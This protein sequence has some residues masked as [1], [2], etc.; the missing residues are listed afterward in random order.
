MQASDRDGR[1]GDPRRRAGPP[2]SEVLARN[3]RSLDRALMAQD[4]TA[5]AAFFT[6]DAV[7]GESGMADVVGREAI[8]EFLHKANQVRAVTHH[9]LHRDDLLVAGEVAVEVARFDETKQVRGQEPVEERGRVVLFWRRERD[10]EWR[11]ARLV[12]SDLP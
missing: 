11:I 10:G 5:A 2:V 8:R 6:E 3:A 7:F 4:A 9:Q 12:V 1:P